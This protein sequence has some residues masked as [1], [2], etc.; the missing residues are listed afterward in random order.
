MLLFGTARVNLLGIVFQA[1]K[2]PQ[3][4]SA[5]F[6]LQSSLSRSGALSSVKRIKMQK[7][8]NIADFNS[9]ERENE[10]YFFFFLL[11]I[12]LLLVDVIFDCEYVLS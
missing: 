3:R 4:Q 7:K 10:R 8:K 9:L 12:T 2:E 6:L 1:M 5:C 11:K